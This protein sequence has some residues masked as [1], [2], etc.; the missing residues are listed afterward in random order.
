MAAQA[1][2]SLWTASFCSFEDYILQYSLVNYQISPKKSLPRFTSKAAREQ[3]FVQYPLD[4]SGYGDVQSPWRALQPLRPGIRCQNTA[5]AYC[6]QL[7]KLPTSKCWACYK[8]WTQEELY[9]PV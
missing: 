1:T 7:L 4:H 5:H 6:Q 3:S 8:L 9:G 2:L